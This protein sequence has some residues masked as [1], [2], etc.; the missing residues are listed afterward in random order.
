VFSYSMLLHFVSTLFFTTLK[1]REKEQKKKLIIKNA[2]IKLG[3]P[4]KKS[5]VNV[6]KLKL[7]VRRPRFIAGRATVVIVA[8][9]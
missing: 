3:T 4:E 8:C 6:S 5:Q 2:T 7:G 1:G 9:R